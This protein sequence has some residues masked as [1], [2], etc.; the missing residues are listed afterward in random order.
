MRSYSSLAIAV[1][2][3][4][5]SSAHADDADD[6]KRQGLNAAQDKN[7]ELARDLFQRS[8]E[9][10]PRPLT[11]FNL[12]V[13]QEH[14]DQ[15]VEASASYTAFLAHPTTPDTE[16][17]RKLAKT[18]LVTLEQAIP[19]LTVHATGLA[20]GDAIELDGR[21]ASIVAPIPLDPG[22]PT[23]VVRRGR[24][25]IVERAVTLARSA[26]DAVDLTV[27]IPVVPPPRPPLEPG[28]TISSIA[29]Q[30][31]TAAPAQK[32]ILHSGWFW[33][34]AAIVVVGAAGTGYYYLNVPSREPTRG[35]FGPGLP[36]P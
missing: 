22:S 24:D 1:I 21:P 20:A 36:V 35:T 18:A 26:R 6:L 31:S 5:A 11:L 30:R 12:A 19:M 14:T 10:D 33:G 28:S 13:A 8:Y 34:I 4:M 15:L 27:P 3:A 17:F 7:W 9:R 23:L 16:P 32:S 25:A 29:V 2:V